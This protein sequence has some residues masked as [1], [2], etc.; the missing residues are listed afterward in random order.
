MSF[1]LEMWVIFFRL[2]EWGFLDNTKHLNLWLNVRHFNTS[3]EKFPVAVNFIQMETK[4]APKIATL[5]CSVYQEVFSHFPT[6]ADLFGRF[7]KISEDYRRQP[8]I[9][10]DYRRCTENTKDVLMY[11]SIPK[12]PIPP[13]KTP[14]HLTFFKNFG[15]IPRYVASLDGQMPHPLELQRGANL[16]PSRHVKA[17]VERSSAKFSATTN[18]L[19]SLSSLHTLIK[20]IFSATTIL[21]DNNR[22]KPRGIHK[23]NDPWTRTFWHKSQ[24][25]HRAGLILCQIPHCTELKVSQMPGDCP[26]GMSGFEIDS[27]IRLSKVSKENSENFRLYLCCN[28]HMPFICEGRIFTML[29]YDFFRERNPCN[30]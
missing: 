9:S 8:K 4:T 21:N 1:C 20:G 29:W 19:F 15:Q 12:P 25:P 24:M 3:C 23:S 14:G 28:I 11:R 26:G 30:I 16:P 27:Y 22:K 5:L 17:T 10:E 7:R 2:F 6:I 13:G 18:F